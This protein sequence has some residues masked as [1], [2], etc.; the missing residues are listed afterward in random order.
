MRRSLISSLSENGNL[1]RRRVLTLMAATAGLSALPRAA[2]ASAAPLVHW[3]GLAMGAEASMTLAHP[4]RAEAEAIIERAVSELRRLE[5]L[6]S[7]YDQ[8]SVLSRLNAEGSL[9]SVPMEFIELLSTAQSLSTSTMGAFDATVQPLWD[10][11]DDHFSASAPSQDGP[12]TR[13]LAAAQNLVGYRG[14]TFTNQSVAFKKPKMA[15]TFNGIAQGYI[16][17][18]I[19]MILKDAG[20]HN[21]LIDMGEIRGLGNRSVGEPWRVG[22]GQ[23]FRA[24]GDTMTITNQAIATSEP[25]GTVFDKHGAFHHLFD[26]ATGR[27][28]SAFR[29]LSVIAPTATLAD[30]LSTG[31]SVATSEAFAEICLSFKGSDIALTGIRADGTPFSIRL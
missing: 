26:P 17:D 27:P 25:M 10:L 1:S 21:I 2:W 8:N 22:L 11:Y 29:R 7:L 20:L 16:T 6:F 18:R 13:T 28:A 14:V 12:D 15:L 24:G 23:N 19:T 9:Q 5:A 30:G 3:K 4:D 31:L